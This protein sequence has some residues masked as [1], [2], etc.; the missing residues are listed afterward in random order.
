MAKK[1]SP[2]LQ[3]ESMDRI[4]PT[5]ELFQPTT[6]NTPIAGPEPFELLV[7]ET[8]RAR[9]EVANNW[10][11][12]YCAFVGSST[13]PGTIAANPAGGY[14]E[15]TWTN[16]TVEEEGC[17]FL[18][19][20]NGTNGTEDDSQ[21]WSVHFPTEPGACDIIGISTDPIEFPGGGFRGSA[22]GRGDESTKKTTVV[23]VLSPAPG[24]VALNVR[25]VFECQLNRAPISVLAIPLTSAGHPDYSR[26]RVGTMTYNPG[27]IH[28][29]QFQFE[30]GKRYFLRLAFLNCKTIQTGR[31]NHETFNT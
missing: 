4:G 6:S 16:P 24:R 7:A 15:V 22:L 14:H 25:F 8:T 19:F 23:S 9:I 3:A 28:F 13:S 2:P 11:V 29:C 17:N 10:R 31:A 27:K 18:L 30:A 1:Q 26:V 21:S 5:V 12:T 20:A